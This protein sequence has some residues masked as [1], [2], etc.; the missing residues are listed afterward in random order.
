M[1]DKIYENRIAARTVEEGE[2]YDSLIE[3]DMEDGY[4]Y[5]VSVND[6]KF[7]KNKLLRSRFEK[8]YLTGTDIEGADLSNTEWRGCSISGKFTDTKLVG[9]VFDDC[10][11]T[12][13]F[14]SCDM[15]MTSFCKCKI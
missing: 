13:D 11:I 9:A 1:A 4:F 7:S 8:V 2:Y 5:A 15:R 6:S 3:G 14:S 12:A 10:Y